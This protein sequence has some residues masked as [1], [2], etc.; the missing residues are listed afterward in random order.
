MNLTNW[1]LTS[2]KEIGY[3]VPITEIF[4][5]FGL[6]FQKTQKSAVIIGFLM[7]SLI[8]LYLSPLGGDFNSIIIPWNLAL[9]IFLY[10]CFFKSDTKLSLRYLWNSN[11]NTVKRLVLLLFLTLPILGIWGKWDYYLS[12]NLFSGKSVVFQMFVEDKQIN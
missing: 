7:H 1:Q 3:I 2:F 12:F 8:I 4:I 5:A 10:S 6:L 11:A 9:I